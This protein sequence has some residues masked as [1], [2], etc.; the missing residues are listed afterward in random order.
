MFRHI[1]ALLYLA[2]MLP[3]LAAC[4]HD[5]YLTPSDDTDGEIPVEF[6]FLWPDASGTRGFDEGTLKKTFVTGDVIHVLGT[7]NTE[8]LQEDGKKKKGVLKRYG[9]LRYDGRNWVTVEGEHKLTWPVIAVDGQFEAYYISGSDGVLTEAPSKVYLLSDLTPST[10]PL[11]AVSDEKIKYGHAVGL[12]FHHICAHLTLTDLNPIVATSYWLKREGEQKL[13]N[14]FQISLGESTDE[15]TTGQPTLNF[16]FF[17]VPD[18]SYNNLVYISGQTVATT[19]TDE[20]DGETVTAKVGYFLEPGLYETFQICYPAGDKSTYEYLQY[21]Y[22]KIP[23][24]IGGVGVKKTSPDLKGGTTYEL[25]ITKSSGVTIVNPPSAEG[26]DDNGE[27]YDIDVEEF[28]KAIYDKKEYTNNKGTK[29]LEAT[30]NGTRLLHNVDFKNFNYEEFKD[31]TFLPNN[32]EGSVFDGDYHYIKNLVSPLFRYN[33]GTIQNVGID[34]INITLTSYENTDRDMSRNGALCM[35]NREHA[36][37]NNV[38]VTNV[39]MTVNVKAE[40]EIGNDG[41]ETHNI[42]CVMGSNTGKVSGLALAGKFVLKVLNETEEVNASVLI[43]GITGQNAAE[44]E[45]NDV[46]F[47]DEAFSLQITNECKGSIGSYSVGGIVGESSGIV[48]DVNLRDVTIDGSKSEGITSYMGGIAGQL[49][50]SNTTASVSSCMVSGSVT[51]GTTEKHD[52]VAVISGSYIGGI[53]GAVL[54]VP[55]SDCRT[56]MSV[57]GSEAASP[58]VIYATGGAFGR[59]RDAAD[60]DFNFDFRD[61]IVFGSALVAPK[62]KDGAELTSYTGNFA[63]IVPVGQTWEENYADNNI[64]IRAF[65]DVPNIGHTQ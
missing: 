61:L 21:D 43:G 40:I 2:F 45:I 46:A 16:K 12:N 22:N 3:F 14:A 8:A 7:F 9:A 42:G 26:W 55:V 18:T 44:G 25:S 48:T 36:T 58:G 27:Y 64:I 54:A 15:E 19:T 10:D 49:S 11:K 59:I 24:D 13:N 32:M 4:S 17:Q 47:R 53:A 29:I 50:V 1:K 28:L 63:G 35:W 31:K 23:E 51:A 33:Y 34:A 39:D 38:R 57:Y 52:G 65:T 30:A 41:S 56:A 5:W 60:Y 37:I 6:D 20:N 62:P